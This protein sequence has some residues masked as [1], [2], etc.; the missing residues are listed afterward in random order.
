MNKKKCFGIGRDPI[1]ERRLSS[2][3]IF[4]PLLFL[5]RT[6][7][8]ASSFG[9]RYDGVS[10]ERLLHLVKRGEKRG[11]CNRPLISTRRRKEESLPSESLVINSR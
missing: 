2:S 11:R 7:G 10:I 4:I 5:P 8:R 6:K 1:I 9:N 3:A